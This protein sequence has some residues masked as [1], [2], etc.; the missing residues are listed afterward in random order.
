M[1]AEKCFRRGTDTKL[2]FQ[3]VLSAVGNPSNLGRKSLDV[4][5]FLLQKTFGN[6]HRHTYVFMSCCLKHSVENALNILPNC[7]TVRTYNHTSLYAGVFDKLRLLYDVGVPL[8]KVDIHRGYSFD[9]FLFSHYFL[10]PNLIVSPGFT[11][12]SSSSA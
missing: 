4:I 12:I 8:G 6:E 10:S 3:F 7:V 5:L 1:F 11:D 2:F 9:H